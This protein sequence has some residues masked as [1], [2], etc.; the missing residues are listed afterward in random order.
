MYNEEQIK[1]AQA[2]I[3]SGIANGKS[4]LRICKKNKSYKDFPKRDK[5]YEWLN[6]NH[7]NFD[8]VFSDNY[9]RARQYGA[10]YHFEQV[11][12]IIRMVKNKKI[13]PQQGRVM[14]DGKKWIAGRMKPNK[15][16]TTKVDLTTGGKEL[17]QQ[18]VQFHLPYNNRDAYKPLSDETD[19]DK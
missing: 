5:I 15:Y 7:K 16:G 19:T 2:K 18:V 3:I 10:D 11:D 13:D 6:P 12:E 4:L 9:A 1:K 8:A 14:I 17:S